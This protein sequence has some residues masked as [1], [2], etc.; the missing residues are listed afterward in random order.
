MQRVLRGHGKIVYSPG[1]A[2]TGLFVSESAPGNY[3]FAIHIPALYCVADFSFRGW[4]R[5]KKTQKPPAGRRDR[6][7]WWGRP[8]SRPPLFPLTSRNWKFVMQIEGAA[9]SRLGTGG[10]KFRGGWA[11]KIQARVGRAQKFRSSVLWHAVRD[12]RGESLPPDGSRTIGI[13]LS[14]L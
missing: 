5:Q 8:R 12:I 7:R 1:A 10:P 3:W 13:C 4:R 11:N 14:H 2:I 9:G 6:R